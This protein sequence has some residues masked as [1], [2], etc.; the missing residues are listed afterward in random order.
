M[1]SGEGLFL[2]GIQMVTNRP[3]G[4]R[5]DY[6]RI[7]DGF[8][9]PDVPMPG[10]LN[11][12]IQIEAD[13]VDQ[14]VDYIN[15]HDIRLV[16]VKPKF[17]KRKEDIEFVR[18]CPNIED[19][20]FT[21]PFIK[22][23][24]PLYE[25]KHLKSLILSIPNVKIG[26]PKLKLGY[27][28]VKIDVSKIP[29]LEVLS[30]DRG[31]TVINLCNCQNLKQLTMA[32]YNPSSKNLEELSHLNKLNYLSIY[33]SRV[34]SLKGLAKLRNLRYLFIDHFPDLLS[35]NELENLSDNL[36]VLTIEG[37]KKIQD[38]E[39]VTSL[40]QLNVLKFINC[41]SLPNL[42]FIKHMPNLRAF[43][44]VDTNIEDGDLTPCLVLEAV[45]FND[46]KHYSHKWKDFYNQKVPPELLKL[47]R[48]H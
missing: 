12:F 25:L 1:V 31:T 24:S 18:N 34:I 22:D 21:T 38:F 40:K 11:D 33:R 28:D 7:V 20:S 14:Y 46:R 9:F 17:Y 29:S 44:F 32:L 15:A 35:I 13:R 30:V 26:T 37:C 10:N 47:I 23:Y 48:M 8:K 42:R 3:G 16:D 5:E 4:E 2:G 39:L 36:I 43:V 6:I 19:I 41:G 45:G 27:P